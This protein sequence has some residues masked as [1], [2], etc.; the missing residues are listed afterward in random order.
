MCQTWSCSKIR[1]CSRSLYC[2]CTKHY[3]LCSLSG[4]LW[5][6]QLCCHQKSKWIILYCI[7]KPF[8]WGCGHFHTVNNQG[9]TDAKAH[10]RVIFNIKGPKMMRGNNNHNRVII[11]FI[12]WKYFLFFFKFTLAHLLNWPPVSFRVICHDVIF[13]HG[14]Q[15]WNCLLCDERGSDFCSWMLLHCITLGF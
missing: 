1:K 6:T 10:F 14:S 5:I 9:C 12:N 15:A 13:L 2:R 4:V 7:R 8:L 11:Y 3:K